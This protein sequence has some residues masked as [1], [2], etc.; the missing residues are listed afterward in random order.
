MSAF[1]R[2][3]S[4]RWGVIFTGVAVGVLAPVL[5]KLGNPGNM[6]VCVACFSR[7]ISGALGLHRA[8]VVQYIRPEIIGFVLGSLVA[9]LIFREFRPRTGSSPLAR[10]FL[11]MLS[12]TGALVFLGCPWRAYLRLSGGDWNAILGILGLIAGIALGIVFLRMGFSLGRSHAAPQALGWIMPAIMIGLLVLLIAAPQF[13]RDPDGKL[14]GPIFFSAKGPGS[15]HAL[16][17]ISLSVGLLI[18]FLAQRSRFCTVGAV[19]DLI[20]LRDVHLFNGVVALVVAA[21]ATNMLLGQFRSGFAGQPIA[22]SDGL[23]NFAGM[24]LAGLAFTLAG[25]CPGRQV[26]LSGEGDGD[27]AIFVL[28][29]IVGAGFTHNFSMASSAAGPGPYGPAA[30]VVGLIVCIVLGLTMRE[31]AAA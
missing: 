2:F 19:R 4:S 3:F 22:H 6:G 23:W 12:M 16:V 11:G 30:T 27:A 29:L 31:K 20:L 10:F 15:Q 17:G 21:F 13:G 26:F 5:V 14:I 24:V 18:G 7:D 8:G 1:S 25:G 9:A 28:G